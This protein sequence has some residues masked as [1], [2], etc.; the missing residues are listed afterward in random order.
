MAEDLE[1]RI[2]KIEEIVEENNQILHKIR[3]KET[4]NFWFNVIK[5]LIFV[6]VFYY[7]YLFIQPFLE[8][9]YETYTSFKETVD[10]AKEIKQGINV[11]V[12]GIDV[13]EFINKI[14][15]GS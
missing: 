13:G 14:S 9:A 10:T 12:P 2:E 7:G 1:S 8:H 15:S 3:R 5:I 6:G 11:G 4:F